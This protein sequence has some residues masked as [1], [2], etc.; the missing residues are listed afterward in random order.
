MGSCISGEYYLGCCR[1]A[2]NGAGC[3]CSIRSGTWN[4]DKCVFCLYGLLRA[5]LY[6]AA[7]AFNGVCLRTDKHFNYGDK[8]P[9]IYHQGNPEQYSERYR[10]RNR[11]FRCVLRLAECKIY[12]FQLRRARDVNL[13]PAF[14]LAFLIGLLLTVV[15]LV[16]KV[17]GAI[18]IGIV[19]TALIGIPMGVTVMTDA[20]SFSQACQQLPSTFCVIFTEE[21][22]PSLFADAAKIPLVLITIFPSA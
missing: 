19:A 5:G 14:A 6:V 21:G 9:Q 22:L 11:Y 10:R 16:C 15:L 4:G 1:Y 8:T 18:L 20:V 13:R 3:K 12:R 2:D 17:K 7:D